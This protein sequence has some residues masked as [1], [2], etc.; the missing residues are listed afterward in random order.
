MSEFFETAQRSVRSIFYRNPPYRPV[1]VLNEHLSYMRKYMDQIGISEVLS[2]IQTPGWE[3]MAPYFGTKLLD[4][5]PEAQRR[6]L[7]GITNS[8]IE[9][10][11]SSTTQVV[12]DFL[13]QPGLAISGVS[14]EKLSR[15]AT[16]GPELVSERAEAVAQDVKDRQETPVVIA[17]SGLYALKPLVQEMEQGDSSYV[18]VPDKI[19]D[20]SFVGYT[21]Y[22]TPE[23]GQ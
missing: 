1:G 17:Y 14:P 20:P 2:I 18:V 19:D 23:L 16:W 10:N 13:K 22:F 6:I 12:S 3:L 15:V 5:N 11:G 4:N 9:P 8:Y 21:L 7:E